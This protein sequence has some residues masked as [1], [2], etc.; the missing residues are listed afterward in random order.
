[1][2]QYKITTADLNQPS[3]E[4]AYLD[5]S[6]PIYELTRMKALGGLLQERT[7]DQSKQT[8]LD[9]GASMSKHASEL[10][11]Y[12]RDNNI[13]PGD[14]EWFKLWFSRPFMTGENPLGK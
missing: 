11:Q 3:D 14:P 4:D 5:P 10:R 13:R 7:M 1:M 6:D 8:R 9:T 2:K 12:E